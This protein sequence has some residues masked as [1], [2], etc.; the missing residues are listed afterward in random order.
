[1]VV[2][3][4]EWWSIVLFKITGGFPV[5]YLILSE[6]RVEGSALV[7]M[8]WGT[9]EFLALPSGSAHREKNPTCRHEVGIDK[10]SKIFLWSKLT[11]KWIVT[12]NT[13]YLGTFFSDRAY[14]RISDSDKFIFNWFFISKETSQIVNSSRNHWRFL[15]IVSF[16]ADESLSWVYCLDAQIF[17][18]PGSRWNALNIER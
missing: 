3:Y 5:T 2:N 10:T 17:C 12:I 4:T 1:M 11:T 15:M 13:A 16:T 8:P 18:L 9:V 14:S 6:C 7:W